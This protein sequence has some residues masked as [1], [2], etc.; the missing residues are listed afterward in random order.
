MT[1][2]AATWAVTPFVLIPL[3]AAY[4]LVKRPTH[5]PLVWLVPVAM[6]AIGVVVPILRLANG[7]DAAGFSAASDLSLL[8]L[9]ATLAWYAGWL[10]AAR[11]LAPGSSFEPLARPP[12]DA[13]ALPIALGFTLFGPALLWIAG[14]AVVCVTSP[15]MSIGTVFTLAL[16]RTGSP[17]IDAAR[18][19]G[20]GALFGS[21]AAYVGMIAVLSVGSTPQPPARL[22]SMGVFLAYAALAVLAGRPDPRHLVPLVAISAVPPI[23]AAMLHG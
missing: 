8:L 21:G 23:L 13:R 5:V 22:A 17:R 20:G 3:I 4:D 12:L 15:W 16:V 14:I 11:F 2:L 7:L 6:S 1:W 19:A 10:G 18:R 9:S